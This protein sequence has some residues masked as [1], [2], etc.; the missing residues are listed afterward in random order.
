MELLVLLEGGFGHS[1]G[2]RRVARQRGPAD[3]STS[4]WPW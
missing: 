1:G 4:G 3:A 2:R